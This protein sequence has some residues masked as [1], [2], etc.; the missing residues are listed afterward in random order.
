[1]EWTFSLN[2]NLLFSIQELK[3]ESLPPVKKHLIKRLSSKQLIIG[4]PEY[5]QEDINSNIVSTIYVLSQI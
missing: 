5:I 2:I 4:N 1:M 3:L